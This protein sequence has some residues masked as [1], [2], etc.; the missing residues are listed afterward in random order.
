M[1][2]YKKTQLGAIV[3]F[4][5]LVVVGTLAL[6]RPEVLPIAGLERGVATVINLVTGREGE[7]EQPVVRAETPVRKEIYRLD[8]KTGGRIYTDNLKKSDGTFIYT[9]GSGMV[10]SIQ[11]HEVVGLV[12]FMEGEEPTE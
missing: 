9:T 12:S 5:L 6:L 1:A 4:I 8:L 11:G 3:T 7:G 10:V 2:V